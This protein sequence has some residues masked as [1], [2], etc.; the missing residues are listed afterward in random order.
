MYP[1]GSSCHVCICSSTFDESIPPESNKDCQLFDCEME[2]HYFHELRKGCVPV[3]HSSSCCPIRFR[4][5]KWRI[6]V[7]FYGRLKETN[8]STF[9]A[10]END[11]VLLAADVISTNTDAGKTCKFGDLNLYVGQKLNPDGKCIE[12]ICKMPPMVE[13]VRKEI[14]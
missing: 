6:K 14:C 3:Y 5:R 2:I 4:C 13:C 7:F 9:L 11:E 12:C 8:S 10:A 1:R